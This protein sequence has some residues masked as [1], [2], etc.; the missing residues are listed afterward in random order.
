MEG[1][2]ARGRRLGAP[3]VPSG[4]D[5]IENAHLVP[6]PCHPA[7]RPRTLSL[8]PWARVWSH[9]AGDVSQRPDPILVHNFGLAAPGS[10][11]AS[12]CEGDGDADDHLTGTPRS[13]CAYPEGQEAAACKPYPWSCT[14]GFWPARP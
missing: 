12:Q 14:L 9:R 11:G 7:Q 2:R 10:S 1:R 4:K 13:H 8:E 5:P 6:S 3:L